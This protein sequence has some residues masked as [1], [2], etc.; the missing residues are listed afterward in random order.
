AHDGSSASP[1]RQHDLI[2]RKVIHDLRAI[3]GDD[4]HIFQSRTADA[5]FSFARLNSD[6]HSLFKNLRMVER[7]Q[8]VDDGHVVTGARPE[9][10]AV[11]DFTGK[12]FDFALV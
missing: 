6:P 3:F 5:R 4:E 7:P 8:A 9:A 11:A 1:S 12:H 10:D 2:S